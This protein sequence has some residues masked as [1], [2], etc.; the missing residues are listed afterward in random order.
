MKYLLLCW[1]AIVQCLS[2]VM[3]C[4]SYVKFYIQK[5]KQIQFHLVFIVPI[6][7]KKLAFLFEVKNKRPL[8]IGFNIQLILADTLPF[9]KVCIISFSCV[10]LMLF[11][12]LHCI[13][14]AFWFYFIKILFCYFYPYCT[15][16]LY[17]CTQ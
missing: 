15:L 7:G 6:L 10:V 17:V 12:L 11:I 2:K 13:H 4:C 9:V 3:L 16:F 5:L 14:M 8:V 1:I